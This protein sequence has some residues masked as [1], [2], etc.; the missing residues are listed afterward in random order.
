[1]ARETGWLIEISIDG[2]P[3]WWAGDDINDPGVDAWVWDS[4]EAVRFARK[5]DADRVICGLLV[6]SLEAPEMQ[7]TEHIWDAPAERKEADDASE[8][9]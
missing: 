9:V 3:A 2:R 8:A 7:A 4:L 5:E 1:M 6:E